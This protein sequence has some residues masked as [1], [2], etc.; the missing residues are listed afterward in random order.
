[1]SQG[2][3]QEPRR[4]VL[5]RK[6]AALWALFAEARAT[7]REVLLITNSGILRGHPQQSSVV[8]EIVEKVLKQSNEESPSAV[9]V[10]LEGSRTVELRKVEYWTPTAADV[11]IHLTQI[12]VFLD[13][14]IAFSLGNESGEA[15]LPA[16]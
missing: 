10:N 11:H 9:T 14:V 12:F 6:E 16:S 15:I 4:V 1:M 7:E 13:E 3:Q 5:D 2:E 8:E